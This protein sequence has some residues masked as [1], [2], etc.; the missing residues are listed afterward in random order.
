MA[1]FVNQNPASDIPNSI[2]NYTLYNRVLN[3]ESGPNSIYLSSLMKNARIY[4]IHPKYVEYVFRVANKTIPTDNDWIDVELPFPTIWIGFSS[5]MYLDDTGE[6]ILGYLLNK[7]NAY[8]VVDTMDPRALAF[9]TFHLGVEKSPGD[10]LFVTTLKLL[11]KIITSANVWIKR[12]DIAGSQQRALR[13]ASPPSTKNIP[14]AYYPV[15]VVDQVLLEQEIPKAALELK[16]RSAPAYRHDVAGHYRFFVRRGPLND[17]TPEYIQ[18]LIERNYQISISPFYEFEDDTALYLNR[19]GIVRQEGEYLAVLKSRVTDYIKGPPDKP[20]V[21]GRRVV[22]NGTENK[23][24][25]IIV[26]YASKYSFGTPTIL[27]Y[28]AECYMEDKIDKPTYYMGDRRKVITPYVCAS[29]QYAAEKALSQI[30]AADGWPTSIKTISVLGEIKDCSIERLE[31][32]SRSQRQ[33]EVHFK[34]ASVAAL[35]AA[36]K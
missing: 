29:Y 5:D 33:S 3:D 7:D 22:K 26:E 21:P 12:K 32:L 34:S 19:N 18:K 23:A 16:A 8:A 20:Y 6:M 35:A 9:N 17:L 2:L 36:K 4:D 14:Q 1:R 25:G 13:S 24:P 30:Q 15:R 11:V 28:P 31:Q 10:A 27:Y